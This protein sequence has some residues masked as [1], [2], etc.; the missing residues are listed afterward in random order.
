MV[1]KI[2]VVGGV[3]AGAGAAA[4][5]RRTDEQAEIVLFEKGPFVSFANCGLP[6]YVGGEIKDRKDLLVQTPESLWTR[7]RIKVHVGHEVLRIDR[8]NKQVEVRD[9]ADGKTFAESY[10]KLILCPGAGAVIPNLPGLPAA[11]VFTLRTIPDSDA[12]KEWIT[13]EKPKRAVIVGAGFIGL[14]AAERQ[15]SI[16]SCCRA[17]AKWPR[18]GRGPCDPLYRRATGIE[19]GSRGGP[20]DRRGRGDH[21]R[22]IPADFRY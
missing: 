12:I 22:R 16:R 11:N 15:R 8:T 14:E 20:C 2:V 19:I 17:A 1:R 6:Y 21:G 3:A 18:S 5:A 9:L 13:R 4:K 10:D 7:F